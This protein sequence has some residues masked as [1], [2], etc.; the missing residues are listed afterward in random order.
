MTNDYYAPLLVLEKSLSECVADGLLHE[1]M[2][3][4][5]LTEA[6]E[7]VGVSLTEFRD[8]ATENA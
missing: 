2:A 8:W 3:N 5:C 7:G 4:F 1:D 6:C